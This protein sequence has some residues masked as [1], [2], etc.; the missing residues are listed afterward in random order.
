MWHGENE[1]LLCFDCLINFI[2][3]LLAD[4]RIKHKK[5]V[6]LYDAIDR[7]NHNYWRYSALGLSRIKD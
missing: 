6:E 1:I 3:A 2:P 7:F 5:S 4:A